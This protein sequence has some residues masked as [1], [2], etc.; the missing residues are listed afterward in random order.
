MAV[1]S[2]SWR[3]WVSV[4][5]RR[6]LVVWIGLAGGMYARVVPIRLC[7]LTRGLLRTSVCSFYVHYFAVPACTLP[8]GGCLTGYWICA[9]SRKLPDESGIY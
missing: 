9:Q 5:S 6:P 3:E 2:R 8:G 4:R 7:L 1:V